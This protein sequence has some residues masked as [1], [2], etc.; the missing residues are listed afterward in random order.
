MAAEESVDQV[1]GIAAGRSD[2][3]DR[4]TTSQPKKTFGVFAGDLLPRSEAFSPQP[5]QALCDVRQL[6]NLGHQAGD[7]LRRAC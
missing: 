3:F 7:G 4:S 5:F 2:T 1:L 6:G